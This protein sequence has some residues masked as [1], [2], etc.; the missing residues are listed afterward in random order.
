MSIYIKSKNT[1]K[2]VNQIYKKTNNAWSIITQSEWE[3]YINTIVS[4]YGGNIDSSNTLT[5]GGPASV[6]SETCQYISL[7]N[8][9]QVTG[10]VWSIVSGT[11]YATID[12]SGLIT[13]LSGAENSPITISCQYQGLTSTKE[14]LVTYVHGSSSETESETETITDPDTGQTT[15]TTT[16]TTT[17]TDEQGNVSTSTTVSEVITNQD[18]SSSTVETVE[19][20]A[21]D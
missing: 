13:I 3:Q 19:N 4:T 7:Y 16:T 12:T 21:T 15:E 17:T 2:S 1:W 10:A 5:I 8:N 9:V 6:S 14:V 20:V 11:S 18:G